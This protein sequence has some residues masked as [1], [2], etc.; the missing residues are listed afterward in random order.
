MSEFYK[1]ASESPI[2][3]FLIFLL[4]TQTIVYCCD[5]IFNKHKKENENE[6]DED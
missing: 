1:F 5:S 2:L 4:F 6:E 3:T